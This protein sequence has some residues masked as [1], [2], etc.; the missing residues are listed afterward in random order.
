MQHV[1]A[2]SEGSNK[3]SASWGCVR[4]PTECKNGVRLSSGV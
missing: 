2:E 3:L 4:V 1:D